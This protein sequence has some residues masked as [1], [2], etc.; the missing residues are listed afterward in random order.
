MFVR[1]PSCHA[2]PPVKSCK[3]KNCRR[4]ELEGMN[5][6]LVI[7]DIDLE[8]KY[9]IINVYRVFNPP[10]GTTQKQFFI[11]QLNQ[12]E[13]ALLNLGNRKLIVS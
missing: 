7:V 4:I 11:N 12:M 13:T 8:C 10:G 1:Y 9:W 2:I 6:G 5:K 3:F